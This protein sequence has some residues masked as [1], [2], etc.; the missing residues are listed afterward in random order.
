MP[1]HNETISVLIRHFLKTHKWY[2]DQ[3]LFFNFESPIKNKYNLVFYLNHFLHVTYTQERH[4]EFFVGT[5]AI[6]PMAVFLAQI[7]TKHLKSIGIYEFTIRY[8]MT[9]PTTREES[10]FNFKVNIKED[11][12]DL[13]EYVINK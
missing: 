5:K 4:D 1:I 2:S 10:I 6:K 12:F 7:L 9:E 8:E 13:E 3:V 11:S